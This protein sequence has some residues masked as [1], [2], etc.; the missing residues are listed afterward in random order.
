MF[1]TVG[2][3]PGG[4]WPLPLMDPR[5]S[6]LEIGT[7]LRPH[8]PEFGKRA[9]ELASLRDK[10]ISQIAVDLGI[11]ESSLQNWLHQADVDEDASRPGDGS[12]GKSRRWRCVDDALPGVRT[13]GVQFGGKIPVTRNDCDARYRSSHAAELGDCIR[14][15]VRPEIQPAG[16]TRRI[17]NGFSRRRAIPGE[18]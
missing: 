4:A 11:A 13:G 16:K 12:P 1:T 9:V 17:G 8:P 5:I 6:S 10:P 2:G 14:F 18:R 15:G 3:W 7:G